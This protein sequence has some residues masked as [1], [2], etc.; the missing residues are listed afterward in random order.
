M[1]RI[2][3]VMVFCK[4]HKLQQQTVPAVHLRLARSTLSSISR[5]KKRTLFGQLR[6]EVEGL[7]TQLI[8]SHQANRNL[9]ESAE[10]EALTLKMPNRGCCQLV[11]AVLDGSFAGFSSV[12]ISWVRA[13]RCVSSFSTTSP[14]NELSNNMQ[15]LSTTR[16][17]VTRQYA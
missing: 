8:H 2:A 14:K 17:D 16:F 9:S 15:A 1:H 6:C 7:L 12:L 3:R 10:L 4:T 13:N 11:A 5:V